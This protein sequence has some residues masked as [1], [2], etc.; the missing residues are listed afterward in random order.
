MPLSR[1]NVLA[2]PVGVGALDDPFLLRHDVDRPG[3]RSLQKFARLLRLPLGE[4]IDWAWAT[5]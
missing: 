1:E 3:R 4:G 5:M 2:N